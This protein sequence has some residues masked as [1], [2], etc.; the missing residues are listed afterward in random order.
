MEKSDRA[1]D[2]LSTGNLPTKCLCEL[3]Q[4]LAVAVLMKLP[5]GVDAFMKD[6]GACMLCFRRVPSRMYVLMSAQRFLLFFFQQGTFP[7]K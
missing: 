1:E 4:V 5:C 3:C 6:E 2:R 7:A